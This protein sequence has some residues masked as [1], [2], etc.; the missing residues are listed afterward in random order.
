M[1]TADNR[2]HSTLSGGR[3]VQAQPKIFRSLL[4]AA[5]A[6]TTM[7]ALLPMP[8]AAAQV[9]SAAQSIQGCDPIDPSNC[10]FPF[11]NN[12]YTKADA[13]TDTGKRVNLSP[14]AM[15]R[16]IAG[17]PIDPTEWNRN[18]GF[19]PGAM[20]VT[21]VPGVDLT[22]TGAPPITD[23]GRSTSTASPIVLLDSDTGERHPFWAELDA[24]ATSDADTTLV[25]H[26]ASNLLEG[27][28][29]IVG[30]SNMRTSAGGVIPP[31]E[32]FRVYRDKVVGIG[33]T[34][35]ARRSNFENIF[36]KLAKAGVLRSSLFLAW[37]F[38][39]ASE[40]SLSERML[41][42]RDDAFSSLGDVAADDIAPT[43]EIGTVENFTRAQN[44]KIARRVQGTFEVPNY[45]TLPRR[46]GLTKVQGDIPVDCSP[47]P[48]ARFNYAGAKTATGT[49]CTQA[50][51]GC[52]PQKNG[53]TQANFICNIPHATLPN[54]GGADATV[55]PARASLYGHGL[56]G[57]AG[58][59]NSGPQ[60]SMANEHN[61]VYCAT[62]WA[63][64]ATEDIGTVASI[65]VDMGNF[66]TMADQVQQ[67]ILN[68]LYL[69]RLMIDPDGFTSDPAF[70]AGAAAT[71]V[72]E[73]RAGNLYY[74]GNSQGGIIGGALTAVAQDFTRA[75]L[76][77]P[78][79]NYSLLLNR[80]SDWEAEAGAGP[81]PDP[82]EVF[83]DP[84]S[85]IPAY[86][87]PFYAAYPD[88]MDQQLTF[89][90]IQMLWDRAEANG[91][92]QHMTD[93]P[94]PGTPAHQVLMH[95]AFGDHQVTNVA[96]DVEA[97][98]I[99][100]AVYRPALGAGR[101]ADVEPYWGLPSAI[102]GS[103]GSAMVIWDSGTPTAPTS[104]TPNR[105]GSDPHGRPRSQVSARV[106]KSAF[107]SEGGYFLDVCN[108]APCLAP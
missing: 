5:A 53:T 35:E 92:S 4:A 13:T 10:L 43:F 93:D 14:L 49:P 60:V 36:S 19:S 55:H 26:P 20:I 59:V 31:S 28:R 9:P 2:P 51:P 30:L 91:Y 57:G 64:M 52:L 72:I 105:G 107:M 96:A 40:R 46:C 66:P 80:S 98:T 83:D 8:G 101:H 34:V 27:H 84:E 7:L 38:T 21:H 87:T 12:F 90:L 99:G 67:G 47:I 102:E 85:A 17:K 48:G 65:L 108:D 97:R 94:Y 3:H 61:F 32:A 76:G 42:I 71:P 50:D 62:N 69:G 1:R 103:T 6:L 88:K 106:Q 58:E 44:D 77:V 74:D 22:K 82:A 63:G 25:I 78:G 29:Y 86:S 24:K 23:I 100:A 37:D 18:D 73:A 70:Q 16:N 41:H 81:A 75:T 68:F 95:V 104:N 56:L 15:P 33:P 45:L 11:P 79:M 89:S 39:V 54:G